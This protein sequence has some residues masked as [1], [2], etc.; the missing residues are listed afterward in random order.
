[1]PPKRTFP[2]PALIPGALCVAALAFSIYADNEHLLTAALVLA[3]LTVVV[4]LL[5][6]DRQQGDVRME[7]AR[8]WIEGKAAKARVVNISTQGG[9][10]NDHPLVNLEL[11]V[12]P[13]GEAPYTTFVT[14]VINLL[15]IPRIQP[16]C[17]IDVRYDPADRSTVVIDE[18]LTLGYKRL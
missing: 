12:Q 10:L 1:M 2:L 9:G 6:R 3:A 17:L 7:M 13:E 4:F 16:D 11:E 14:E 18:S 15:A 8:L 5:Y